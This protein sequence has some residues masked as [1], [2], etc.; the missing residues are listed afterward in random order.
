MATLGAMGAEMTRLMA[1]PGHIDSVLR[2]GAER[3]RAIAGPVLAEVED[4]VGFLR[5]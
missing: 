2:Q 1:D 5:S 4:I 3:A